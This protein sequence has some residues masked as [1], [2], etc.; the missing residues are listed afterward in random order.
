MGWGWGRREDRGVKGV[1]VW[2]AYAAAA[3]AVQTESDR[4]LRG[5]IDTGGSA[6][7][8]TGSA[9]GASSQ[10]RTW[11]TYNTHLHVCDRQWVSKAL[12]ES[13][14]ETVEQQQQQQQQP[15]IHAVMR[16]E[17]AR[18]QCILDEAY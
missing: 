9:T 12:E 14:V 10:V 17:S 5:L 15:Y 2:W 18:I 7:N 13:L 6:A 11:D 3:S 1:C 4:R 8:C 16:I